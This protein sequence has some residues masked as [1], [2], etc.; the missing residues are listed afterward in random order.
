MVLYNKIQKEDQVN[1]VQ[2]CRN[3]LLSVHWYLFLLKI[4]QNLRKDNGK[5]II[6][7]SY[8]VFIKFWQ[9][10]TVVTH[11]AKSIYNMYVTHHAKYIFLFVA[12]KLV[13]IF[14]ILKFINSFDSFFLG[15]YKV[16]K[17]PLDDTGF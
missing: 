4:Q 10:S 1:N 7:L 8:L 16:D 13:S 6:N 2:Y 12:C 9:L 14:K 5:L 11:H 3:T 15:L 17:I